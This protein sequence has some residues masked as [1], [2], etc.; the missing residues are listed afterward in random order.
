VR[1]VVDLSGPAQ[2]IG[3]DAVAGAR[4][5]S[6]PQLL[7]IAISDR[8]VDEQ[9]LQAVEAASAATDKQLLLQPGSAHGKRLLATD[10]QVH[11]AVLAFLDRHLRL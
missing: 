6:V 9:E 10:P 3:L 8:D 5:S 7:A 11:A 4:V 1:A 2:Y